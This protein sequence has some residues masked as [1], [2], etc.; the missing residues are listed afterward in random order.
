MSVI[1]EWQQ[2]L[3]D[4]HV[5]HALFLYISKAFDCVDHRLLPIKLGAVELSQSVVNWV[6]SYLH[7]R[8]IRT[9]EDGS[10]SQPQPITSGVLQGSV[11]GPL[12][13][14][15]FFIDLPSHLK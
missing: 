5:V 10:V 13:F 9:T 15:I 14:L 1:E 12:L 8:S 2:A 7:G 11:L 3:D 4:D 6:A